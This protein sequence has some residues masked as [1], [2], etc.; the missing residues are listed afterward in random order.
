MSDNVENLLLEHL[1]AL[2]NDVSVLRTEMHDE[3]RDLKHRVSSLEAA[4]VRLRG[5]LVGMQEDTYRQ[6]G[7]ID[8][9]VERIERI[10]RRLELTS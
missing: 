9:I 10:E 6:Q 2:R 1:K 3:F 5:D 7:R 4:M 8:Q